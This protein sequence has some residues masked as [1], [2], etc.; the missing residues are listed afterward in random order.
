MKIPADQFGPWILVSIKPLERGKQMFWD[1]V[2]ITGAVV[3]TLVVINVAVLAT[4]VVASA[5]AEACDSRTD[6]EKRAEMEA[7]EDAVWADLDRRMNRRMG[8]I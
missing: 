7:H 2:K 1:V 6:E 3:A 5:I 8:R 4:V